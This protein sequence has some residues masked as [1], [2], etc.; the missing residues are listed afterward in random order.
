MA[1]GTILDTML[2]GWL[3]DTFTQFGQGQ[4]RRLKCNS[5]FVQAIYSVL[6]QTEFEPVPRE[7]PRKESLRIFHTLSSCI[8]AFV[9]IFNH[10]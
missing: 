6:S 8:H 10:P 1:E 9:S 7:I 5:K 3:A 4:I 2:R